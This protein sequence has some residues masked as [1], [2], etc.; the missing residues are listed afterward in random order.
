MSNPTHHTCS[1]CGH[2]WR[3]G[4]HGGHSCATLM[5]VTIAEQA[6]EIERLKEGQE[7]LILV[8]DD[9]K[10][11]AHDYRTRWASAIARCDA[12]VSAIEA[13]RAEFPLFDDADLDQEAHHCEWSVQH[14][15]KRLHKLIDAL[16]ATAPDHSEQVRQMVPQLPAFAQKVISKLKRFEE[17]TDDGQGA[18][19]G[20]HWFDLLTQLGLLNRVQRSPGLWEITAQGEDV[21][22]APSASNQGGDV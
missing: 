20:R 9:Y 3:H 1:T 15:R 5:A 10:K 22:T 7:S 18:D 14:D 17:C 4:Q 2:T 21:L 19:I 16:S 6:R 11:Q 13:I 12:P 8:R